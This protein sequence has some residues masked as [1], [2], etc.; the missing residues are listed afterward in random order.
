MPMQMIRMLLLWLLQIEQP[1]IIKDTGRVPLEGGEPFSGL[2]QFTEL[3][4]TLLIC[5]GNSNA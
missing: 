1:I 4:D 3:S 2:V 5:L